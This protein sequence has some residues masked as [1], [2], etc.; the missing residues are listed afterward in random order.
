MKISQTRNSVLVAA[1][2]TNGDSRK[3]VVLLQRARNWSEFDTLEEAQAWACGLDEPYLIRPLTFSAKPEF[4]EL[5]A[6][7]GNYHETGYKEYSF[8]GGALQP[9]AVLVI[10]KGKRS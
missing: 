1:D 5:E 6:I 3:W 2:F 4:E 10:V 7:S 8:L 9:N